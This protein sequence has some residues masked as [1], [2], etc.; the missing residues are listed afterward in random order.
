MISSPAFLA[1]DYGVR[2]LDAWEFISNPVAI[3]EAPGSIATVVSE[4]SYSPWVDV[5]SRNRGELQG[6]IAIRGSIFEGTGFVLSGLT[7]LDPQTGHYAAEIPVDPAM[8]TE[9]VVGLGAAHA[10][11]GFNAT[12]GSIN[13]RFSQIEDAARIRLIGG[14]DDFFG[15]SAYAGRVWGD[16]GWSSDLAIAYS[17]SE[18][19]VEGG[20]HAFERIS[21]RVQWVNEDAAFNLVAGYQDKY[22]AWPYLYALQELHDLIGTSG[23]ET[24]Q[25][26]T[27][28]VLAEYERSLGESTLSVS[29]YY[30]E[31]KDDYEFDRDQPGLFN[32]YQHTTDVVGAQL[33]LAIPLAGGTWSS[34]VQAYRDEIESTA[35]V[36]AP[37]N[38]REY[39]AVSTAWQSEVYQTGRTT[40]HAALGV[41]LEGSNRN[42]EAWSPF[43]RW[44]VDIERNEGNLELYVDASQSTKLAGYTAIGSNENGGLFRGNQSLNR[45]YARAYE[46]GVIYTSSYGIEA[47]AAVFFREDDDLVDWTFQSGSLFARRADNVDI[48]T[49]GIEWMTAYTAGWFNGVF[50]YTYLDKNEDYG[51]ATSSVDGSFYALNYAQHRVTLG[52]E[53][54]ITDDII[55]LWDQEFRK[56]AANELRSGPD[57]AYLHTLAV[58]HSIWE[59]LSWRLSV[60]N[61]LDEDFEEVPGVPGAG[62]SF[63][64]SIE[65]R[66]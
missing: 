40:H 41:R 4:L 45:E 44:S 22:F 5:Q 36:F 60:D 7:L 54:R 49:Y 8:L 6:D 65:A 48:D 21:G 39:W 38:S 31:N 2:E 12:A 56:Q 33:G 14:T 66:Y 20:E 50:S 64:L 34:S 32:A 10:E 27:T 23:V 52:I 1:A 17:E 15:A 62:R 29:G 53:A 9:A 13:Y 30:R 63:S 37:F 51:A 35:L 11:S 18:G 24:E 58:E 55:F 43:A 26:E 46:T 42:N 16:N 47:R 28:L 59:N 57:T 19:S 61:A 25:I 3:P